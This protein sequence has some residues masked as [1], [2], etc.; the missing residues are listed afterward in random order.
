M[1]A[2]PLLAR[3]LGVVALAFAVLSRRWTSIDLLPP[4]GAICSDRLEREMSE[5][6]QWSRPVWLAS[7]FDNR[8]DWHPVD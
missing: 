4:E 2:L 7:V 5:R 1:T 8:P 6:M 3:L